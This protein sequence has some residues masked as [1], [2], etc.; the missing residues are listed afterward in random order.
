MKIIKIKRRMNGCVRLPAPR[1]E[2]LEHALH[3]MVRFAQLSRAIMCTV[4]ARECADSYSFRVVRYNRPFSSAS[5]QDPFLLSS[6]ANLTQSRFSP[7]PSPCLRC[8]MVK[9]AKAGHWSGGSLYVACPNGSFVFVEFKG[10]FGFW[11]D[12]ICALV[13]V[14]GW[15]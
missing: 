10:R 7:P 8:K 2:I 14:V 9:S 13:Q 15:R 1:V 11:S 6:L 12:T 4:N 5:R 3:A